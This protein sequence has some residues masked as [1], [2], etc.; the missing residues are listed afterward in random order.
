MTVALFPFPPTPIS[1]A[2]PTCPA[3]KRVL[4]PVSSTKFL[5]DEKPRK[6]LKESTR[7]PS[8]TINRL[9]APP[10]PTQI[11]SL[12][13]V[14]LLVQNEP[15]PVTTTVLLLA[16]ATLSLMMPRVAFTCAPLVIVRVLPLLAKPMERVFLL[17]QSEP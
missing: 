14:L 6:K 3:F 4:L 16:E 12:P 15:V 13:D 2:D 10:D 5:S 11:P 9:L 7:A 8:A 17:F 1:K